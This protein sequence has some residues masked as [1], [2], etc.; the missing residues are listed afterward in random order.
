MGIDRKDLPF[1][2]RYA[3]LLKSAYSAGLLSVP[4]PSDLTRISPSRWKKFIRACHRGYDNAQKDVVELI[5][6]NESSELLVE[7][8]NYRERL[9]RKV[10]DGLAFVMT[11]SSMHIIKRLCLHYEVPKLQLSNLVRYLD[12][13][14][15]LNAENR[16]S[17]AL[18]CDL[19]TFIH[20]GDLLKVERTATQKFRIIELKEGKVNERIL[21]VLNDYEPSEQSL[22]ILKSDPRLLEKSQRIQA[23]RIMKQ[24]MRQS[25][26]EIAIRT[27]KGTDLQTGSPV[28]HSK[29]EYDQ[30]KFDAILKDACET[31][32]KDGLASSTVNYCLHLSVVSA[33]AGLSVI[34]AIQFGLEFAIKKTRNDN[35]A[36]DIVEL[37]TRKTIKSA[38]MFTTVNLMS[39]NLSQSGVYPFTLW[40]VTSEQTMLL[41]ERKLL[42]YV[43]ID[44]AAFIWFAESVLDMKLSW[45]SRKLTAQSENR[46]SSRSVL[47]WDNRQL[48]YNDLL[49]GPGLWSRMLA[50]LMTPYSVLHS[51]KRMAAE[52]GSTLED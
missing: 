43:S 39:F 8:K 29:Y 33:E 2:E 1:F 34:D 21:E 14:N 20:V 45:S 12:E 26:A 5:L 36:I 42:V 3:N 22:D 32:K 28:K 37:E 41:A 31:A 27:D 30:F 15:K 46:L 18:I 10:M 13:A 52:K 38:S 9:L 17:F 47:K 50:E 16:D 48:I 7:E 51:L 49:I 6:I 35:P 40:G 4:L 24:S 25:Q 44:L 19:T 11:G 23:S